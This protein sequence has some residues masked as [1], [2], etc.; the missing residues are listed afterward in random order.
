MTVSTS[1][2]K[3]VVN[4]N[5]VATIFAFTFKINS[6]S[7]LVV[8]KTSTAG[9]DTTL[10]L[11]VDYSVSGVGAGGGG[12]ITY[13][14]TGTA[15]ATG[16]RITMRR[17]VP[18]TQLTDLTN[19]SA[20]YAEVH[21]S[22]FDVLVMADQQLQEQLNRAILAPV[23]ESTA[24]T[25][26]AVVDRAGK[27]L[28]FDSSGLPTASTVADVSGDLFGATFTGTGSQTAF[29][30]PVTV[31]GGTK[32]LVVSVDGAVQGQTAYSVS[33]STLTFTV[34]PPYLAAIDVR[35]IGAASPSAADFLA[36]G[37][38][39]V[40]RSYLSKGRDVISVKDFGAA[41]NGT[42][43]DT[44]ALQAAITAAQTAVSQVYIPA[45]T[46]LT[47]SLSIT[48][49]VSVIGAGKAISILKL[50][51]NGTTHLL[52][53]TS[54]ADVTLEGFTV[55]GNKANQSATKHNIALSSTC[56]RTRI[57]NVVSKNASIDGIYLV[58]GDTGQYENLEVYDCDR[59]GIY[60][61][62]PNCVANNLTVMRTGS[63]NI[64]LA[65][66]DGVTLTN[67]YCDTSGLVPAVV[68]DN[69]TGYD[70]G[71]KKIIIANAILRNGGN[72]GTHLGGQGIQL[73]NVNVYNPHQSGIYIKDSTATRATD[74][75]LCNCTVDGGSANL[76]DGI[77]FLDCDRISLINC[78]TVNCVSS[79]IDVIT[80]TDVSIV[81]GTSKSNGQKGYRIY[82]VT[83]FSITGVSAIS[84]GQEGISTAGA[85]GSTDGVITVC[86]IA[87]NTGVG[88]SNALGGSNIIANNI[89]YGN[90]TDTPTLSSGSYR[91]GDMLGASRLYSG[92]S[93]TSS[94]LR[95]MYDSTVLASMDATTVSLG[96]AKGAESL[97]V[98]LVASAV[99]W[100]K[101]AGAVTGAGS[102][103]SL[104]AESSTDTNVHMNIQ[105]QGT[106]VILMGGNAGTESLRI[107]PG[108]ASG[109][110]VE[111]VGVAAGSPPELKARG[112]DTNVDIKFT[113]KGTG[114]VRFGTHTALAA[115]TLSGYVTI[116]D[117]GG[118]LR[119][120]GIIS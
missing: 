27:Y 91:Y 54:A 88:L 44:V 26:P 28:T 55:D 99:N 69:I 81:G 10:T 98:G 61:G 100:I 62:G 51:T 40:A 115:E 12:S 73:V 38:G 114:T 32:S 50:K 110:A 90:G 43:D 3:T 58:T 68:A 15:L 105:A 85:T 83:G 101:V 118:T 19:Q 2:S 30:L 80:S 72:H 48:A 39:A 4:G 18:L 78:H 23:G 17:V 65:V 25:L 9:V 79:G 67:L 63:A 82:D 41:G 24:L 112:A 47:N 84:N 53:I 8:V 34:A 16:E 109:N 75:E 87:S 76:L 22:A 96:G 42:T 86:L 107:N 64:N 56:A 103:V 70:G 6:S 31:S 21:E 116:K 113:P 106:G 102:G 11:G 66:V 119:K 94:A 93:K 71:N 45:G 104:Q 46:Y 108:V 52:T 29:S 57:S 74:V 120:V 7:D 13:P 111:I 1:V 33:G 5:G 95:T 89:I 20:F 117:A 49:P 60:I 59:N 37:T 14:L 92:L 36:S 35:V 97:R 77:R